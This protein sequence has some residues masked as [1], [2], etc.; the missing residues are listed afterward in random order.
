MSMGGSIAIFCGVAFARIFLQSRT[1]TP[2][3]DIVLRLMMGNAILLFFSGLFNLNALA[4]ISI[5]AALLLYPTLA[6]VSVVR[7][8]QG[9]S[10]ALVFGFAWSLLI[11]G[12]V[13]QAMRDLGFVEH[14]YINYYWPPVASFVE[15]L[16]IMV[17]MGI[18]VK[19]LRDQKDFAE[20]NYRQQM[21]RSKA[22]LEHLVHERTKELN[23]AKK[24]A[25]SEARTDPLTGIHNRRNF[26]ALSNNRIGLAK[27]K[28]LS[29]CMLMMDID[30][31]KSIND[32]FGHY[33]GDAS[34]LAFSKEISR[35]I[36][37][38]DIFG[39]MGGE[40]F[41]V[42]LNEDRQGA[43]ELAERIREKIEN[44]RLGEAFSSLKFTVSIGLA[45]FDPKD[46]VESLMKKADAALYNA[47]ESGRNCVTE[48]M[49]PINQASLGQA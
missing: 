10:E 45:A 38:S 19:K 49:V 1:F 16:T 33:A 39:R 4:V 17:A 25:E 13:V 15:M 47:K 6:V 20:H 40:E 9:F 48:Y 29:L 24:L 32:T 46:T 22:E 8:R 21:E 11:L 42:L 2:K 28:K 34:L 41:A 26:F 18:R 31:F 35:T 36:R 37:E 44:L 14:N 3:L 12:L 23:Q 7:W 5:T 27:R 43:L 30:H